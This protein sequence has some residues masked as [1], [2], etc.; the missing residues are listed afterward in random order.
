RVWSGAGWMPRH[1][2]AVLLY[3]LRGHD[4]RARMRDVIDE[5][6]KRILQH[7]SYRVLIDHVG[8]VDH[9]IQALPLQMVLGI[10]GAVETELHRLRVER[11]AV[12]ERDALT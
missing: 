1:L 7:H 11:R 12:M 9:H 3:R 5:R 10:A 2:L 8:V 4:Q 6:A